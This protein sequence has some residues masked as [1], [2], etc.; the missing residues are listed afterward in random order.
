MKLEL[1]K[2]WLI[3]KENDKDKEKQLQ[4]EKLRQHTDLPFKKISVC[5]D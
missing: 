5:S 2:V 1:E 4:L 3:E